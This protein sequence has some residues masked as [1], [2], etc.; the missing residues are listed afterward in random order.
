LTNG[1]LRISIPKIAE[2]R[3]RAIPIAIS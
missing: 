3:G 2:Q 1:E